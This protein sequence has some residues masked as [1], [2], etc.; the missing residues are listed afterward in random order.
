M[1][2]ARTLWA[3]E[4]TTKVA[5][6]V[7]R[8][9]RDIKQQYSR[10]YQSIP[11]LYN[12]YEAGVGSAQ[13][14][15]AG[16]S[17]RRTRQRNT[18]AEACDAFVSEV[19]GN[20]PTIT[21][22]VRDVAFRAKEQARLWG[23]YSDAAYVRQD[24]P[25]LYEQCCRDAWIAGLGFA[26]VRDTPDGPQLER[27]HPADVL[28]DDAGCD[29]RRDP[30]ELLIQ[31]FIPRYELIRT[32]EDEDPLIASALYDCQPS[33][34]QGGRD[35]IC[36]YEAWLE[37][38]R[39]VLAADGVDMA[40]IDDPEWKGPWP[41]S[42]MTLLRAQRGRWGLSLMDRCAPLQGER[43]EIGRTIR[44]GIKNI[45]PHLFAE[46]NKIPDGEW[47]DDS[48]VAVKTSGDPNVGIRVVEMRVASPEAFQR[49]EK[50]D[51]IIFR[52][53][54]ASDL[55]ASGMRQSG[56]VSGK[57]LKV[58]R[59]QSVRR[60]MPFYRRVGS[61]GE[62][63]V[64]ELARGEVRMHAREPRYKVVVMASGVEKNLAATV[65]ELDVDTIQVRAQ[66]AGALSLEASG[67]IDD[68]NNLYDR[69]LIDDPEY[70]AALGAIE[71]EKSTM[72]K[73]AIVDAVDAQ[74][75]DILY[76]GE[77]RLLPRYYPEPER[78]LRMGVEALMRAE[79]DM[80]EEL[81]DGP[82]KRRHELKRR[83]SMLQTWIAYVAKRM[84][85]PAPPVPMGMPGMG[86]PMLPP[87]PGGPPPEPLGVP[88]APPAPSGPPP[89]PVPGGNPLAPPG[90]Q[91]ITMPRR[92][93]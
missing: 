47:T 57:S 62:R 90:A 20:P 9:A 73:T 36:C 82:E 74:L 28:L 60:L 44:R 85:P 68:L 63:A 41:G 78:A 80:R 19:A 10:R 67:R 64:K 76:E 51:D 33:V 31:H 71:F 11:K 38:R 59:D 21:I 56:N 77:L 81:R 91:V 15:N 7:V 13:N 24:L 17:L 45:V 93:A 23:W 35:V 55:F 26:L 5:A 2:P 79:V 52:V 53:G 32:Y 88:P 46:E 27:I 30:Q 65:L 70:M 6:A 34:E 14:S 83:L 42:I 48:T 49:E 66:P 4:D 69:G 43:N 29:G 16:V 12:I 87:L 50:I 40:L 39:H 72:R 18:S 1:K 3:D 22:T 8:R 37:D 86:D 84:A 61:F 58:Q 92:P 25:G 54:Q 75:D 89:G